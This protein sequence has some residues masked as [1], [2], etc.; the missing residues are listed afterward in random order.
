MAKVKLALKDLTIPQKI[1]FMRQVVTSMTGNAN[2]ATP[3]PTLASVTAKAD[4][5]ETTYNDAQAAR[6]TAQQ[7]TNLQTDSSLTADSS[8]TQLA[9]YVE[10]ITAG[11]AAKIQSA[12]MAVRADGAPI[13]TLPAPTDLAATVGDNDGEIDL[14]WDNVRGATSYV[15]Q[16][17]P[18][19]VTPTSWLQ[20]S[21][22]TKSKTTV[23]SLTSGT[24][25]WF[26]V[27]AVGTAGQGPWSDPATKIAP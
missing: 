6:L 8:M 9:A 25:Y 11:D 5:L 20:S 2:F 21:V 3:S 27:S 10:N 19:P 24:K 4:D 26:R 23:D 14:D 7:K 15:V 17:S 22:V 16:K 1:Q 13:G 12:G 18:D